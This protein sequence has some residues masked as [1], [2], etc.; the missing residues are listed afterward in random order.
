MA[1]QMLLKEGMEEQLQ[2]LKEAYADKKVLL[3]N[4]DK[5][6]KDIEDELQRQKQGYLD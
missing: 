2:Q 1:S 3:K 4:A 5:N 6:R